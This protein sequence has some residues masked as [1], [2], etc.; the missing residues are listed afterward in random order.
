MKI[1]T[2]TRHDWEA[3]DGPTAFGAIAAVDKG[4]EQARE[5]TATSNCKAVNQP[6]AAFAGTAQSNPKDQH[7][8]RPQNYVEQKRCQCRVSL[9]QLHARLLSKQHTK[10]NVALHDDIFVGVWVVIAGKV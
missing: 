4:K 3:E 9:D 1:A 8:S 5:T 6:V 7:Q 10:S 2:S